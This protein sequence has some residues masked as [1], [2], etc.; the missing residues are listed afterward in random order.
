MNEQENAPTPKPD[1]AETGAKG[2]PR[3]LPSLE[4]RVGRPP[5]PWS[6]PPGPIGFTFASRAPPHDDRKKA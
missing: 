2:T 4:T 3:R 1:G 5:R 6:G